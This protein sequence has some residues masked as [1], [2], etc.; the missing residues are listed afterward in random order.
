MVI[1]TPPSLLTLPVDIVYRIL[2]KLSE[3]DLICSSSNV[4]IRL[5]MIMDTYNR[6]KVRLIQK[7]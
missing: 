4:C 7:L 6:Y 2:D 5:N 1:E 3:F